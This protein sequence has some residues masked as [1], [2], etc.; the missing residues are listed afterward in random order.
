[1]LRR[2]LPGLAIASLLVGVVIL[3]FWWR[4]YAHVDHFTIGSIASGGE[5][6]YTSKDGRVMV[7]TRQSVGEMVRSSSKFYEHWR[8]AMGCLIVPGLWVAVSVR[9]WL[10]PRPPGTGTG[11]TMGDLRRRAKEQG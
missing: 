9:R 10:L 2:L 11:L 1:M 6:T 3:V 7:T 4:S 8:L 5:T